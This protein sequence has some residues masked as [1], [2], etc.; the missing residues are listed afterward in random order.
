MVREVEMAARWRVDVTVMPKEG[1]NDPQG[2]SVESGLRALG[3]AE[4]ADVRIGKVITLTV[5]AAEREEATA[6]VGAM[7]DRLLA[8]PVIESYTIHVRG[9][10]D[11]PD[12]VGQA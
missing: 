1:V 10:A 4:A 11:H 6:R 3:F 8:N 12:K 2:A 7:C 9:E 5:S